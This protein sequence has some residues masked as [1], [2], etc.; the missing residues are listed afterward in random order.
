M[1]TNDKST[2]PEKN[3]QVSSRRG[4][5]SWAVFIPTLVV[6]FISLITVVFP[7]LI[8]RATSP[9]QD[10]TYKPDVIDPYQ[11]GILA[12]PLIVINV[13]LLFIG[14][15]Y[16]KKSKGKSFFKWLSN[17]NLSKKRSLIILAIILAVFTGATA[18]QLGTEETWDDYKDVKERVNSWT[19]SDFGKSFEPHI[20]FLLLSASLNIFGN[21]RVIPFIASIMLLALTYFFT[22]EITQNRFAGIVSTL[23]LI[24]SSIFLSYDTSATYD[25]FWILLYLFSLYLIYKKWQP[26]PISYILSIFA[27]AL[28]VIFLPMSLFFIIRSD[29]TKKARVYSLVSYGAV[30]LLLAGAA[31]ALQTNYAGTALG[32]DAV[33]FWKGF[34]AMALQMR[35]DYI[36]V[37]F[38][39]PLT[40][41]LF[42][43][44]RKGI[45]H[46]DSILI[47]ILTILL[48]EPFLV[49]FTAQT[50]QPY[51]LVSLSVFFAIGVGILLSKRTSA[52]VELSSTS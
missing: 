5:L 42:F 43:A 36:V 50:N 6:V 21:I 30:I 28:T 32:F 48:S 22:V 8:T 45:L 9:F 3:P 10:A 25:S 39:L 15:I 37:L 7:A 40:V 17:F 44:S 47:F 11:T 18:G 13:I 41:M 14:I 20:R 12:V 29:N 1:S 52:K 34:T 31:L 2:K 49:G 16:Y 24:Q 46:A 4:V 38:L 35:F 26:S 23:L 27:K 19:I 51:R 33:D